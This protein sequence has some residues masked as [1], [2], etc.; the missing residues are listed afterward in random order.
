MS[1]YCLVEVLSMKTV[2]SFPSQ[3]FKGCLFLIT[4]GFEPIDKYEP[5][6]VYEL[7]VQAF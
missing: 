7:P 4:L 6:S 2:I 3:H 1:R 5:K